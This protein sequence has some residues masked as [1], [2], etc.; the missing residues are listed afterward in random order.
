MAEIKV[1]ITHLEAA[2]SALN[3]L[4]ADWSANNTTPPPTLGGGKTVAEFE[5]LSR[6]YKDLNSHMVTL[7]SNTAAFLTN[8]KE[9]YVESDNKAASGM[10]G[11]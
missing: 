9:S 2:I 10:G 5:E 1:S 3:T 7:V 8:V 4:Q 6:M 11:R